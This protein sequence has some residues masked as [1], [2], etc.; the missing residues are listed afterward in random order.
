MTRSIFR[1]LALATTSLSIL[2]VGGA[3]RAQAVPANA[4]ENIGPV[5][6]SAVAGGGGVALAAPVTASQ[7]APSQAPLASIE[8][9]SV[10]G[11]EALKKV[12]PQTDDYNDIV[13]LTPSA[14]DVSPSGPGLQQDF[15]QS[16]RGLQYTQFSVLWDGI[17]VPGFPFNLAPQP[18]A[19]F[20]G[21]DFSSVTVNRGPGQASAVGAATFGGSVDLTTQDPLTTPQTQVYGTFGSFGTKLY[22]I[23]GDSGSIAQLGGGSGLLDLTREEARGADTGIDTERR[24]L[25]FKYKQPIGDSTVVT[26]AI[27]ADND[28]TLTPYGA[29]LQSIALY[30]RNYNLNNN[31]AS[32]SFAQYNRDV[33]TTDFMYLQVH[34]LLGDGWVLDNKAYQTEY[35][36]RANQGADVGGTAANLSGPIYI[37]GQQVAENNDVP[38]TFNH[39]DYEDWGDVLRVSKTIGPG[40]LQFGIW[41]D[42]EGFNTYSYLADLTRDG[43]AYTTSAGANPFTSKYFSDLIT[44]QPYA[45]Y[46][47]KPVRNVTLTAGIKYSSVTRNVEGPIYNGGPV[48]TGATYNQPLPAF[49]ANWRVTKGLALYAQAAKGFLTPEQGLL[50]N[51]G[52]VQP[53][54]TWSYQ[55]GAVYHRRWLSLGADAYYIDFNNYINNSTVANVTTYFNQGGANFKGLEFEG[56]ATLGSGFAA[57]ANGSLNDS[58]YNSNGN[59]LAQTPRRTAAVALLYDKG[60]VVREND[61]IYA[62]VTAKYVGPQ[63]GVDTATIGGFD[64]FAIK[65]WN[66]VDLSAGYVLPAFKRRIRAGVTVT[67]LF[68]HQSITGYDGVTMEGSPLY[69]IQAGRGLFFNIDAYL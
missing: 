28:V 35:I 44:I 8:P 42:R 33:Y 38:G 50:G 18:G 57:Y 27:N 32:Q 9:T 31:P 63:Y 56:T 21:R 17:P 14:M 69:F 15:A 5:E 55:I 47:Y 30:G 2:V 60:S 48:N 37:D 59:N 10:V 19:Y 45:Q 36:Q 53:S 62:N 25:F 23:Q 6:T 43:V 16:I 41:G 51:P 46:A 22:G 7:F 61:D 64:Q 1:S 54:T 12:L 68:N 58:N 40:T 3:A 65:S 11:A 20:L 52:T 29:T 24:N 4:P 49:D 13:L 67:N 39:L 26:F 34:S 66:E